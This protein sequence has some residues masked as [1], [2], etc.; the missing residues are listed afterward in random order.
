MDKN[1][2]FVT[3]IDEL[4]KI[5]ELIAPPKYKRCCYG[6]L[7]FLKALMATARRLQSNTPAGCRY[8]LLELLKSL[9][10]F[11]KIKSR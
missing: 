2:V 9:L 8:N 1:E 3:V 7:E 10:M 5:D 11:I 6:F 4:E